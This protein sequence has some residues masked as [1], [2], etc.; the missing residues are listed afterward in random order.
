LRHLFSRDMGDGIS[1]VALR[2]R[3][4]ALIAGENPAHPLSDDALAASLSDGQVLI[5][6][7]TVAKYRGLLRIPAAHARRITPRRKAM[8]RG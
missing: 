3:L 1:A 4:A 2:D 5:A 7:R 6:R 8:P